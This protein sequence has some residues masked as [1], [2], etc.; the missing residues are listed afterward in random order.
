MGVDELNWL[1]ILVA[2]IMGFVVGGIWYGPIMGQRWLVAVGLTEED[3]Q[4]GSMAMIYGFAF[5]LSIIAS[6]M[7]AWLLSA[8]PN[9]EVLEKNS[10]CSWHCCRIYRAG[11]WHE[12]SVFAEKPRPIFDRRHVLAAVLFSNGNCAW[13]A[14]SR[15]DRK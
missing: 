15:S 8:F 11:H 5:V 10:C 2:A 13:V 14:V 6:G 9:L 4:N 12:L 1:T 7:L 3:V